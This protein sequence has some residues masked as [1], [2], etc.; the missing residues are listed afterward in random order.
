M[1]YLPAL[2]LPLLFL[3]CPPAPDTA[4]GP[5]V[6]P[7]EPFEYRAYPVEN[8][9]R[10]AT[11]DLT[12][13]HRSD[14]SF[15]VPDTTN[16]RYLPIR[17]L[18]VNFHVMN[19]RDTLY[20]FHGEKAEKF[21][22]ELV[23]Y[24]NRV[25]KRTP[26]IFLTPEDTLVPA[27]PR[28]LLLNLAEDSTTTSGYAIYEHYDDELYWYL[29]DGKKRNRADLKVVKKYN[30]RPREELNIYVMGPPRESLEDPDFPRASAVG[31]FLYEAIKVTGIMSTGRPP[32]DHAPNL[33]H[34]IAHALTLHHAWM[35]NDGCDDTPP[36]ANN[37]WKAKESGPGLTSNNL[38]D[39]GPRQE[40]LTPCQ[41]GRMH[42]AMSRYGSVTRSWLNPYWCRYNRNEPVR[43]TK[44]LVW[45]GARDF[46]T[47][48][49]VKRGGI[50][51]I[52]NRVHLPD[53]ATI[54]V[55]PGGV[56]N[57][58]PEAVIHSDC[59]GTWKGIAVG[60]TA[61]GLTGDVS[62]SPEA[63]FLNERGR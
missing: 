39:Y 14:P 38:M 6:L 45:N 35:R 22:K 56:L 10:P 53:G 36:H 49:Y 26:Q 62:I 33:T 50:L 2:L 40:A 12:Q 60:V 31:I 13:N 63:T 51:T 24:T 18:R 1:R 25:L 17:Y 11:Y 61:S 8:V 58:G 28:R 43:V 59:G 27:L 21:L 23:F 52:N 42:S 37:A 3:G 55:D 57:I 46:N 47:D 7:E 54:H 44:P 19:S 15:Y 5:P 4:A 16:E 32:W 41:I 29:H 20:D 48:I 30:V 9:Q 34:E